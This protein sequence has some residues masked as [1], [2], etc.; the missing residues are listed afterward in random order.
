MPPDGRLPDGAKDAKHVRWVFEKMGCELA[1][2]MTDIQSNLKLQV[3]ASA[4]TL[5][6][7]SCTPMWHFNCL[8]GLSLRRF[9]DQEM[10]ALSGAHALG[11]CHPDRSGWDGPWTNAPTTF[12]NEYFVQLFENK[13]CDHGIIQVA[14]CVVM[15][16]GQN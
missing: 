6:T 13:W 4:T 9:D 5:S 1:L 7:C 14:F 16:S 8:G 12:S 11:R 10:V 3:H 2:G 15:L